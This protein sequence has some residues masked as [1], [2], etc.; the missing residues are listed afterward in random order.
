VSVNHLPFCRSKTEICFAVARCQQATIYVRNLVAVDGKADVTRTSAKDRT[1]DRHCKFRRDKYTVPLPRIRPG[2]DDD[3]VTD[4]SIRL[5][6]MS[7]WNFWAA[8]LMG[9]GAL[10]PVWARLLWKTGGRNGTEVRGDE[11]ENQR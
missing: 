9:V 4:L 6:R 11:L 7:T 10:L 3:K 2:I 1:H 8:G 5:Q